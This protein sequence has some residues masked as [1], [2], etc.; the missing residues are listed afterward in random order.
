ME[1]GGWTRVG[2]KIWRGERER[3]RERERISGQFPLRSKILNSQ[4][5]VSC[6]LR[7]QIKQLH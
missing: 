6:V 7:I 2:D 5:I 1:L 4:V 3:E